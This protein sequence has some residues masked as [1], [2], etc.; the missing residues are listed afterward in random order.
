MLTKNIK[1][2][3]FDSKKI[4]KKNKKDLQKFLKEK[5]AILDSLSTNYKD[6]YSK[7]NCFKIKKL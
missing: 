4:D 2:R 3:N 1:F 5:S 7:K 6:S